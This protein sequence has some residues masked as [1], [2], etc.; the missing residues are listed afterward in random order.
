MLHPLTIGGRTGLGG[1]CVNWQ[2]TGDYVEKKRHLT[3]TRLDRGGASWLATRAEWSVWSKGKS[4][5][6]SAVQAEAVKSVQVPA[7][8]TGGG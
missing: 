2:S 5:S 4:P 8:A 1:S 6:A 3:D 7:S